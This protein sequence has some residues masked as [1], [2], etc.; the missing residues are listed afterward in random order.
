MS[1]SDVTARATYKDKPFVKTTINIGKISPIATGSIFD[2]DRIRGNFPDLDYHQTPYYTYVTDHVPQLDGERATDGRNYYVITTFYTGGNTTPN[3]AEFK[4]V[5]DGQEVE[6][7]N[8]NSYQESES[9]YYFYNSSA[10]GRAMCILR[11]KVGESVDAATF[12]NC[13]CHQGGIAGFFFK[14]VLFFQKLFGQNKVCA[15]GMNH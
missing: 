5:Y 14:I 4:V 15:C 13:K 9:A 7:N 12:C 2:S 11:I 3:P 10:N 6:Y 8:F 1:K